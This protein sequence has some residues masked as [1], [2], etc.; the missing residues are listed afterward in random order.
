VFVSLLQKIVEGSL[1]LI[2]NLCV[3]LIKCNDL[4]LITLSQPIDFHFK[5][6]ISKVPSGVETNHYLFNIPRTF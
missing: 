1:I 3:E 4:F 5:F 2:A 6:M